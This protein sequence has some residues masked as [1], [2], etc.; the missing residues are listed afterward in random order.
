MFRFLASLAL[1]LSASS[2]AHALNPVSGEYACGR[3]NN[4]SLRLDCYEAA[5]Y[6]IDGYAAAACDRMTGAEETVACV[7]AVSGRSVIREAVLACDRIRSAALTTE[8]LRTI[9]DQYYSDRDIRV[10]DGMWSAEETISCFRRLGSSLRPLPPVTRPG[11]GTP[12]TVRAETCYVRQTNEWVDGERFFSLVHEW[13]RRNNR[14]AVARIHSVPYSGRVYDRDGR[15]V[16]RESGGLSNSEVD[17]VL[18]RNGL[19]GCE[20]FSC[21]E[22]R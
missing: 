21:T 3:I 2:A 20:Q 17:N 19:R 10:C 13:T 14:C 7:R 5:R 1:I 6:G 22:T 8:C 4:S 18:R 11:G 12:P 16:E 15:R 9:G